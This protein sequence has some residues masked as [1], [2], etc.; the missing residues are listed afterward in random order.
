MFHR[1]L[2]LEWD[3]A[4]VRRS[5]FGTALFGF[6]GEEEGAAEAH[7]EDE[8]PDEDDAGGDEG[9]GPD[10]VFEVGGHLCDG[11]GDL[12]GCGAGAGGEEVVVA[13]LLGGAIVVAL[14]M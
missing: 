12:V 7:E 4:R 13:F 11:G 6:E 3:V 9:F 5:A 10:A 8:E 1:G 14:L 2:V